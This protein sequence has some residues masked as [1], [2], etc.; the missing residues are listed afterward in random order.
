MKI[1]KTQKELL[2]LQYNTLLDIADHIDKILEGSV[3][4][5]EIREITEKQAKEFNIKL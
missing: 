3:F 1:D 4:A 2:A 5:D